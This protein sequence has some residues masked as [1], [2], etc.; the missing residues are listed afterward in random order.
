M[1][2]FYSFLYLHISMTPKGVHLPPLSIPLTGPCRGLGFICTKG[3][4]LDKYCSNYFFFLGIRHK[5]PCGHDSDVSLSIRSKNNI[6]NTKKVSYQ[7][8]LKFH[9]YFSS[10]KS[11]MF[12]TILFPFLYTSNALHSSKLWC[13]IR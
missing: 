6:M 13:T 4:N 7:C 9:R 10:L 12:Y 3:K 5:M 2:G 8:F 1:P 11:S